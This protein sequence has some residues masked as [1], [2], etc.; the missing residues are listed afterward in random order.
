MP[1]PLEAARP[2]V[3][4]LIQKRNALVVLRRWNRLEIGVDVG[5]VRVR[6]DRLLIRRHGAVAVANEDGERLER[7]RLRREGLAG[8]AALSHGAVALP[9][10]VLHVGVLALLGVAGGERRGGEGGEGGDQ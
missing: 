7:H 8:G 4:L 9:A 6:Q 3:S 5:E 10:A 2:R 1:P